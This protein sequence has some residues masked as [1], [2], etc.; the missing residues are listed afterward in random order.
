MPNLALLRSKYT[1]IHNIIQQEPSDISMYTP[2][3]IIR[4]GWPYIRYDNDV[5]L[6]EFFAMTSRIMAI[7][8][9][10]PR[11]YCRNRYPPPTPMG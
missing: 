10:F 7:F 11:L 1:Y 9:R 6:S 4:R 5:R 2:R 8:R 3:R